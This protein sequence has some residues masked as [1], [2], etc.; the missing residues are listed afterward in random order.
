MR[1]REFLTLAAG[2]D[3]RFTSAALPVRSHRIAFYN[4]SARR[5]CGL[6]LDDPTHAPCPRR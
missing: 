1:R 6:S 3:A 2:L 5:E 4:L